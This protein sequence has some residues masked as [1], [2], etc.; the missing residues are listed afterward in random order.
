MCHSWILLFIYNIANFYFNW[1]FNYNLFVQCLLLLEIT[2]EDDNKFQN[3]QL[4]MVQ[5]YDYADIAAKKKILTANTKVDKRH[6]L[7]CPYMKLLD[8]YDIIPLESVLR[9]IHIVPDFNK[10]NRYFVN[11]YV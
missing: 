8:S 7:G 2:F 5:W 6:K 3:L 1:F 11:N 4:V 9:A 10:E